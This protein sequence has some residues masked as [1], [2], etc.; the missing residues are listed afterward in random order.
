MLKNEVGREILR[1]VV[2]DIVDGA[3]VQHVLSF[4]DRHVGLAVADHLST[5]TSVRLI[6]IIIRIIRIIILPASP[7]RRLHNTI[8]TFITR[9]WSAGRTN[10]RPAHYNDRRSTDELGQ[11]IALSIKT[12][13]E[14]EENQAARR[15]GP[16]RQLILV[17][18]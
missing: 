1:L 10:T 15:A 16:S 17:Y 8:Y 12:Y 14:L 4:L 13:V 18:S 6:I 2:D 3:A 5:P 7:R 9:T 11:L